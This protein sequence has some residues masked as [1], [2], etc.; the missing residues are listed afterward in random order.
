[1]P[2]SFH[3]AGDAPPLNRTVIADVLN[4]RVIGNDAI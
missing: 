4:K 1:L 2:G 3:F